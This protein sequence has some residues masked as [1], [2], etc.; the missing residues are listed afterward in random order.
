MSE[1]KVALQ[2]GAIDEFIS[3]DPEGTFK[4]LKEIGYDYVE[5][6]QTPEDP[7]AFK[8]LLDK[9][10]L[11]IISGHLSIDSV[12]NDTEKMINYCKTFGIK[13]FVNGWFDDD[14]LKGGPNEA[15]AI[16]KLTSAG[17]ILK[18]N[19]IQLFHHNHAQEFNSY[20]GKYCLD[21][22]LE[23]VSTDILHP[24][25]DTGWVRY[26]GLDPCEALKK[27][28]GMIEVVHLK[29]FYADN[30]SKDEEFIPFGQ[31]RRDEDAPGFKFTP[32]G[33]GVQKFD[34]II[35]TIKELGTTEMV[36]VEQDYSEDISL[37]EAAK[38]SREYLR[39]LGI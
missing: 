9:Y 36:V 25:I 5:L 17:K 13:Y 18:E 19:G 4:Y 8:A 23:E 1:L 21:W 15:V 11:G 39:S 3:K 35:N 30:Y 37:L 31:P 34:R 20:E 38:L 22:L 24:Q 33:H 27:Y 6:G 32:I 26:S 12:I 10:G 28:N 16:E 29:D 7:V 2:I 14:H